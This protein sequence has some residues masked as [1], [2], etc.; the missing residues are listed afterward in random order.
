MEWVFCSSD[1]RVC[2][3]VC[4]FYYSYMAWYAYVRVFVNSASDV[5]FV[6]FSCSSVVK[7][8]SIA[9][10]LNS[11][12]SLIVVTSFLSVDTSSLVDDAAS[13]SVLMSFLFS[14]IP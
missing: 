4:F 1:S 7:R 14:P 11:M 8:S 3:S 9:G 10:L 6:A 5:V 2:C 12:H 13:L